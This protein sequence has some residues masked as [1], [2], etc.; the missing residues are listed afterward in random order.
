MCIS[1]Q[2]RRSCCVKMA[3]GCLLIGWVL[4]VAGCTQ[5]SGESKQ[6]TFRFSYSVSVTN[7]PSE[8]DRVTAW[9][10]LPV[11]HLHQQVHNVR[12]ETDYPYEIVADPVYSNRILRVDLSAEPSDER[13][14]RNVTVL[15]DVTRRAYDVLKGD[16]NPVLAAH[17]DSDD[18]LKSTP[19]VPLT[20]KIAEEAADVAEG[21]TNKLA[22]ARKLYEHIVSS[23]KYDKSGKGWGRGDA[24]YACNV[25][26]GNCTDFHSLF[27]GEARALGLPARFIIGFPL[28]RG[29]EQGTIAGYHC[30]AEVYV[31]DVG[32]L[33]V[34]A[35]EAHKHPEKREQFFGGLD[36]DRVAFTLG[37]DVA[38]PGSG[39]THN[40]FIYP[41]VEVDGEPLER[42][43]TRY[44]FESL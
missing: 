25:R 30:W 7:V 28:P 29:E 14:G 19:M 39:R 27:M 35:S 41:Y 17:L 11:D 21:E 33:P 40:Y 31:D 42:V 16:S 6:R 38:L 22:L 43:D 2:R 26:S 34:D 1:G 18:F 3:V 13:A 10:P 37:R 5:P 44:A 15:S 36:A 23:M 20:G 4:L 24:V 32:W 9:I 12:I 8:A